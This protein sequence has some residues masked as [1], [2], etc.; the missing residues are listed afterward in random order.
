MSYKIRLLILTVLL[1]YS[2]QSCLDLAADCSNIPGKYYDV[3]DSRMNHYVELFKDGTFLHYCKK[4]GKE[5]SHSGKWWR[6]QKH[7]AVGVDNWVIYGL[8][9]LR[10]LN[11]FNGVKFGSGIGNM[12]FAPT[13]RFLRIDLDG[14][15]GFVKEKYAKDYYEE[16]ERERVRDSI[17][18]ATKDTLFYGT[19]EVKA[20]GKLVEVSKHVNDSV[21]F[22]KEKKGEWKWFYKN[23]VIKSIGRGGDSHKYNIW[24]YYDKQGNLDSLGAYTEN[25]KIGPWEYYHKNGQLRETGV[26]IYVY[27]TGVYLKRG[28]WPLYDQQGKLIRIMKYPS[29]EFSLDSLY[30]Q[31]GFKPEFIE[32]DVKQRIEHADEYY[33]M[34][35]KEIKKKSLQVLK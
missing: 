11:G 22:L 32:N 21:Y 17:Y 23:G 18:W 5:Y 31:R 4:E 20:I 27:E 28:D 25:A 16:E 26:Y 33:N 29:R 3:E 12:S 1:S 9:M 34:Y 14:T 2:L 8:P 13:K 7:C 35:K 6:D 19:G 30:R 10:Q 24:K 15:E